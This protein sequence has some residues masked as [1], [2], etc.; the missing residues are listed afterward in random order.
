LFSRARIRLGPVAFIALGLQA[1]VIYTDIGR[2]DPAPRFLVIFSYLLLFLFLW[3]NR[4]HLG[5][6]IIGLGL[7]LNFLAI[8][9]NG[10]LMPVSPETLERAGLAHKLVELDIGAPVPNT[11]DILLEEGDTRLWFLSD[12]LA[13]DNP[14]G[15]RAF[16]VGDTVIGAGLVV[17]LAQLLIAMPKGVPAGDEQAP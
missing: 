16:S 13:L 11:K 3:G 17:T 12:I 1:L 6:A 8:A 9:A 4:R 5:I 2:A 10:G 15:V 14:L 7:L